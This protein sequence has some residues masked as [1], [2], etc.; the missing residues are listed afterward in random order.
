M[1]LNISNKLLWKKMN[2]I[3]KVVLTNLKCRNVE[4]DVKTVKVSL[5]I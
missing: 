2:L 3:V 1:N 5:P 4:M